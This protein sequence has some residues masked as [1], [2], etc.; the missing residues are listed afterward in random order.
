VLN[1]EAEKLRIL[2]A[3]EADFDEEK[4]EDHEEKLK[5]RELVRKTD[6]VLEEKSREIGEL[7]GLLESQTHSIGSM[8]VGAAAL[9]EILDSDALI[10]EERNNLARL[11]DECRDK[12][13]QAEVELSLERAKIARERSQL[14]DKIHILEQQGIDLASLAEEKEPEKQRRGRWRARLGLPG[15]DDDVEK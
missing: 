9:G 1:W 3:L 7:R 14:N 2:A 15:P 4:E 10:R 12:L 11:Q 8:A 13:R 6:R 5:I